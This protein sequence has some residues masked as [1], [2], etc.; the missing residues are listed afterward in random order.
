MKAHF[1]KRL[2]FELN[3]VTEKLVKFQKTIAGCQLFNLDYELKWNGELVTMNSVI[4]RELALLKGWL[5]KDI[6]SAVDEK[7]II[8]SLQKRIDS[9]MRS[10]MNLSTN[11]STGI[12]HNA[13]SF[14]E[15]KAQ[16]ELIQM[17]ENFIGY[18]EDEK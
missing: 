13:A 16:T 11:N 7:I 3:S 12:Y 15:L 18:L 1:L 6:D 4:Y 14:Y 10:L 9:F 8:T 2:E 17:F 5:D